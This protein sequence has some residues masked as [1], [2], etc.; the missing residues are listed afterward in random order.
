M[1]YLILGTTLKDFTGTYLNISNGSR[2]S[3]SPHDPEI[4]VW[5]FGG[6]TMFGIGQR[7]NHTIP[8]EVAKLAEADG[9]KIRAENLGVT[10]YVN[11]QETEVFEQQLTLGREKPS[12]AV[13]YDGLNDN[14]LPSERSNIGDTFP[15]VVR[16][17]AYSSY[18][19]DLSRHIVGNADPVPWSPARTEAEIDTAAQQYRRGVQ[20]ARI[21]GEAYGV[22]VMHFWQPEPFS[23]VPNKHDDELWK[24]I[25]YD[26]QLVPNAVQRYDEVRKRSGVDPID[27]SR[28]LDN[29]D[30]PV[31]FDAGHTNEFGA[32]TVAKAMYKKLRPKLLELTRSG[33]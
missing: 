29:L 24:R 1:S 28:S 23:K 9:I 8:S 22:E 12:L 10:A 20:L 17:K 18:E 21:L 15:D 11:W 13:F 5:F 6:S 26:T 30:R 25:G 32:R 2:V 7:D 16:R 27:L 14:S 3:Y 33:N 19:R 4:T 31:Y